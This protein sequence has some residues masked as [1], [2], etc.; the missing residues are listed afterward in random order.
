MKP[1]CKSN[2]LESSTS[3]ARVGQAEN[4]AASSDD[5]VDIVRSLRVSSSIFDL[6]SSVLVL[7]VGVSSTINAILEMGPTIPDIP[8]RC[9]S[10]RRCETFDECFS[11]EF[12]IGCLSS[13]PQKRYLWYKWY[14]WHPSV[15]ERCPTASR[16]KRA[17]R[18][19][20]VQSC[21]RC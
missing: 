2:L 6:V 19:E 14:C 18:P 10:A 1:P 3:S 8:V 9:G 15:E 11:V 4:L 7:G 12:A 17:N 13:W 20:G 16:W 5:T 21:Q